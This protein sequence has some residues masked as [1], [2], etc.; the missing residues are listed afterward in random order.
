MSYSYGLLT[1]L[2]ALSWCR[3]ICNHLGHG[4][5]KKAIALLM[6]TAMQE[7]H[8]GQYADP[9]PN[10]A[11]MGL[12]QFDEIAFKDVKQ[13]TRSKDIQKI[14]KYFGVHIMNVEHRDLKHSPMLSLLFCR[15]FYRLIP[16]EI[17]KTVEDR[18]KYWKKYYNTVKGKGNAS[19]YIHNAK[20]IRIRYS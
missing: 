17:P 1:S 19:E 18:A 8:L 5:N 9:T 12:C 14:Q 6:E 10:G 15:L 13:R 7:T 2:E 3:I 20:R 11:G 16:E 4:V